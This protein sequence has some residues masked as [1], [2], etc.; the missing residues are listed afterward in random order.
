MNNGE[1]KAIDLGFVNAYL[2]RE[3]DSFFL[4]DTGIAQQWNRL[5]SKMQLA[6]CSPEK[7]KLVIIT[8]GDADHTGNCARLQGKYQAK[9]AMH[10]ADSEMVKNGKPLRH[11]ANTLIGKIMLSLT[12][13]AERNT[14]F[15]A[16]EPD[17]L[18]DDG[19][20]L[21]R[22]GFNAR[23][24]HA[25]GHTNGSIAILTDHGLLFSG[26]TLSNIRKPG[27][28]PLFQNYQALKNSVEKLKRFD[29]KMIYP[30]HGKPFSSDRFKF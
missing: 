16:F 6:G 15:D 2:I 21:D 14:S 26:D 24:I 28:A 4:I 7:L 12:N 27:I 22:Y 17:I 9:I 8:H 29:I 25:P 1:I 10:P 30:G 18:L 11:K 5:L 23:V 20:R 19:E 3:N 13:I